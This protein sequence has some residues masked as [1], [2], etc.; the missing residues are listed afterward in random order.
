MQYSLNIFLNL[1][2]REG[3]DLT[4]V[5][6]LGVYRFFA[7]IFH[8]FSR[9]EECFHT[10]SRFYTK[11]EMRVLLKCTKCIIFLNKIKFY[12]KKMNVQFFVL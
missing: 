3:T 6:F 10:V 9:C 2:I 1:W 7:Q 8:S 4:F 11:L 12:K 5:A